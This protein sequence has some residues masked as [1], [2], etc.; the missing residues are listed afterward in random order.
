[1]ENHNNGRFTRLEIVDPEGNPCII[2]GWEPERQCG[3]IQFCNPNGDRCLDI[4]S[5]NGSHGGLRIGFY[6][7]RGGDLL[8]W[9]EITDHQ[10][11]FLTFLGSETAPASRVELGALLG[12]LDCQFKT[13]Q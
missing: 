5:Y 1:M 6:E 9:L 12:A 8:A 13:A 11:I 3:V 4:S 10:K 7:P 2:L